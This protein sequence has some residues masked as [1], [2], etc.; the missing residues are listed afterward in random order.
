MKKRIAL[1]AVAVGL[2]IATAGVLLARG[3]GSIAMR[4]ATLVLKASG[5]P[6]ADLEAAKRSI[7]S[8][9]YPSPAPIPASLAAQISVERHQVGGNSVITLTPRVGASRWHIIYYHGGAYVMELTKPHWDIIG[10][11]MEA[12]GATVTVPIYPLAPE[13]S[14]RDA[15]PFVTEVYRQVIAKTAPSNVVLAGDSAGGGL[16]VGEALELRR[17]GL[18]APARLILFSP[19]LDLT[20]ADPEARALEPVDVMLTV[21]SLRECGKMWA[22]GDDPRLP[23]LSPFYADLKGLPP[24]DLYQGTHDIFVVD[25]R[26][27]VRKVKMASGSIRYAEYPGAFHVFVG[28]TFTPEAK[29]VF[30]SIRTVMPSQLAKSE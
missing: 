21:D 4:A 18:P 13:H 24:I 1:P 22:A 2:T 28:A 10:A 12:T 3:Q 29:E 16:A 30:R 27:F 9:Q 19:W 26:T 8:R 6:L 14:N 17:Q 15:F 11:L 7:A 20:M 5:K 23:R 25:A